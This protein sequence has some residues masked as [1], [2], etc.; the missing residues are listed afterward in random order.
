M[1]RESIINAMD[2]DGGMSVSGLKT[3]PL[4]DRLDDMNGEL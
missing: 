1:E 3:G 4:F 2:W